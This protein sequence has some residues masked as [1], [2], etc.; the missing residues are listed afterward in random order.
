MTRL[1]GERLSLPSDRSILSSRSPDRFPLGPLAPPRWSLSPGDLRPQSQ[2]R[3]P[4]VKQLREFVFGEEVNVEPG[5]WA[6]EVSDRVP[7]IGLEL[8]LLVLVLNI[9]S[10]RVHS[11]TEEA[12]WSHSILSRQDVFVGFSSVAVLE[13]LETDYDREPGISRES[14]DVAD[15]QLRAP[16][17]QTL[18]QVRNRHPGDVQANEVQP[19]LEERQVVA[20]VAA[21]DVEAWLIAQVRE[22]GSLENV[23]DKRDGRFTDVSAVSVLVVPGLGFAGRVGPSADSD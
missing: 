5:L 15:N 21:A 6:L 10:D 8:C 16:V 11:E 17:G 12:A 19:S 2:D 3:I 23:F 7:A 18:S 13:D 20:A 4:V 22:S 14:R 9:S 1:T